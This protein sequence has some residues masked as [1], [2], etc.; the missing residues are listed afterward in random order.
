M[1]L[2]KYNLILKSLIAMQEPVNKKFFLGN[3][4][5]SPQKIPFRVSPKKFKEDILKPSS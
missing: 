5:T 3:K 1:P 4:K 2:K